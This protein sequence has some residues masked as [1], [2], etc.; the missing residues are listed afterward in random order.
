VRLVANVLTAVVAL[1]HV[2]ILVLRMFF[3]DHP[4]GRR[5]FSMTPPDAA[6]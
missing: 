4:V 3:W 2:G 6:T 5:I 1:A